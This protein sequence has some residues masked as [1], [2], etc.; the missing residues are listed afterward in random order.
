M[1]V[2]RKDVWDDG[3]GVGIWIGGEDIGVGVKEEEG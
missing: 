3:E 1:F 2:D